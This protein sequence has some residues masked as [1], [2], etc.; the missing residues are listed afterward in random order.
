MLSEHKFNIVRVAKSK[1]TG[2]TAVEKYDKEVTYAG[3]KVTIK[4]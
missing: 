2:T 3:K 1:G 4:L